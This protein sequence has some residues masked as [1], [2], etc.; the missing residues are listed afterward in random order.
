MLCAER[1]E[2]GSP[3]RRN[4]GK[5]FERLTHFSIISAEPMARA[6]AL[7]KARYEAILLIA[8]SRKRMSVTCTHARTHAMSRW[9][10]PFTLTTHRY[11]HVRRERRLRGKEL[12]RFRIF[13]PVEIVL[14]TNYFCLY[15]NVYFVIFINQLFLI[16]F[17]Y[18][19]QN[20]QFL[21]AVSL[22]AAVVTTLALCAIL[23]L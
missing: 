20:Q 6:R 18:L 11:D 4:A 9:A 15:F 2:S 13:Q 21:Y 10:S 22:V 5:T 16:N 8:R 23:I 14:L 17:I 12:F 7:T 19:F 3:L 1:R